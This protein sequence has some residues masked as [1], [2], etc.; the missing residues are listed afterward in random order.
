MNPPPTPPSDLFPSLA[1]LLR[2]NEKGTKAK[3]CFSYQEIS[4]DSPPGSQS[5]P[6]PFINS[7][8]QFQLLI[9][10]VVTAGSD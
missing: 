7:E 5:N 1:A 9:T 6:L 2:M 10:E 4:G 8:L 3:T